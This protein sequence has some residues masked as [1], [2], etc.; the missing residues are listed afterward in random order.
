[1]KS[2]LLR[3]KIAV[4]SIAYLPYVIY[5][6]YRCFHDWYFSRVEL[7]SQIELLE[8][9]QQECKDNN[10]SQSMD[11]IRDLEK[12]IRTLKQE[13]DEIVKVGVC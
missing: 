7:Q 1:M 9:T 2:I 12:T 4:T 13:K 3:R 5:L 6:S 11:K 8:M 10:L